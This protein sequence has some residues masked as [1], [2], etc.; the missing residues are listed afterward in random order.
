HL[1][2]ALPISELIAGEFGSIE[3]IMSQPA[4]R[5]TEIPEIGE[6]IASS[7]V[8]YTENPDFG[9]LID[10]LE[11]LGVNMTEDKSEAESSEFSGMTFVQTGRLEELTRT[12][13]KEM[14]ENAGGKVTGSV[15]GNTDVV[16]AA[17]DAGIKL[18]KA[19][20]LGDAVWDENEFIEKLRQ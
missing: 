1:H 13:A 10:K 5:F 15:S 2:Y 14:I 12:E 6:K 18:E 7:I 4:E 16:V 20:S 17:A 3:E 19:Q 11:G 8:T 9:A